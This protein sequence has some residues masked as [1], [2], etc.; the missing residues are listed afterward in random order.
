MASASRLMLLLTGM[1]FHTFIAFLTFLFSFAR[2]EGVVVIVVKLLEDAI[3]D[4]DHIYA[5]VS[6]IAITL[7]FL[8]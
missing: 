2:G 3:R 6:L 1:T 4:G 5:S 7:P 8:H